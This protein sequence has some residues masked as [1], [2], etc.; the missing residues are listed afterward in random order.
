MENSLYLGLSRQMVLRTDMQIIANNVANMN[1]PGFRG[2]NTI[3]D[4]YVSDPKGADDPL[5]F[6]LD[7]GQYQVTKEGPVS[8]TGNPLDIALVGPGFFSVLSRD[9]EVGYSRAGNFQLNANSELISSAG[10]PITDQ[11][12]QPIVIPEDSIE[13][14]IDEKGTISNQDGEIGQLNIVEF[15]DVQDLIPFGDNVYKLPAGVNPQP[16]AN[17]RVSQG[18]LEGSNIEPVIEMTRMIDTLRT[19]QSLQRA[20]SSENERLQEAIRTLTKTQ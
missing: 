17:T 1:T 2:Q 20:M 11:G 13:I 8:K 4:E 18:M 3:F 12:G 6:V 14:N 15:G 10:R 19:Y 5:S 16:A 7:R 9:G